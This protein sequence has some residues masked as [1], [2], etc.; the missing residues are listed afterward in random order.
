MCGGADVLV[1][2][3]IMYS[4]THEIHIYYLRL[5]VFFSVFVLLGQYNHLE[6]RLN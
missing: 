4:Y 1:C 2:R 6:Y 3:D 5:V